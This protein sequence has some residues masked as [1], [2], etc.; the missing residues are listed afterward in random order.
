V[1]DVVNDGEA[2]WQQANVLAYDLI[3]LDMILPKLDGVS[4]CRLRSKGYGIPILMT[5]AT[6]PLTKSRGW[7]LALMI[8]L[9]NRLS[10]KLLARIR[11]LPE[12]FHLLFLIGELAS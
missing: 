7:M 2:A 3:L 6:L 11:A 1:V 4:L 8:I 12:V 10:Y 5:A 9:S